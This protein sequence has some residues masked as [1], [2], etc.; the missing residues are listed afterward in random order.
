MKKFKSNLFRFARNLA[1]A[2]FFNRNKN[3]QTKSSVTFFESNEQYEKNWGKTAE[4]LPEVSENHLATSLFQ[5]ELE[6]AKV[7]AVA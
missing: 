1:I 5:L 4:Y 2:K 6:R 3:H 7:T